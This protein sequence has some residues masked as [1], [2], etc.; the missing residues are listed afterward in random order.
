MVSKD[1]EREWPTLVTEGHSPPLRLSCLQA[2]AG[3]LALQVVLDAKYWLGGWGCPSVWPR[4]FDETT[5]GQAAQ[6][7]R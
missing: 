2:E 4:L 5:C 7:R 1:N 3:P 6:K